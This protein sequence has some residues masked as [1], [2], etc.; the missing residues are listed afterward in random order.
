MCAYLGVWNVNF[1]EN[2]AYILSSWSHRKL[3]NILLEDVYE[4]FR[5]SVKN[6]LNQLWR[7]GFENNLA[8]ISEKYEKL[9]K[10]TLVKSTNFSIYP[11]MTNHKY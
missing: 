9:A 10:S 11:K 2:V 5:K 3:T 7:S 4:P 6:T 1:A 8:Q